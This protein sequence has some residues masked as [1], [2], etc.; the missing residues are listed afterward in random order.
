MEKESIFEY[1]ATKLDKESD[2][3]SV[4]TYEPVTEKKTTDWREILT[5]INDPSTEI[6]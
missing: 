5:P 4:I 6:K 3:P 2:Q 1:T